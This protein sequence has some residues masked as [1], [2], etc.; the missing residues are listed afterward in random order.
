MAVDMVARF[1]A[2]QL[3]LLAAL[4]AQV[5]VRG[6]LVARLRSARVVRRLQGRLM[7]ILCVARRLARSVAF[8]RRCLPNLRAAVD[9]VVAVL[10]RRVVRIVER[11]RDPAIRLGRGARELLARLSEIR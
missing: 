2:V 5:A 6:V 10:W 9:V 7:L 3:P 1:Q 8:T 4:A 11:R